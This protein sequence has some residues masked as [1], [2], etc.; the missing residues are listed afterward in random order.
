MC[1]NFQIYYFLRSE[2]QKSK[3]RLFRK[4]WKP[5]CTRKTPRT[6]KNSVF[7]QNENFSWIVWSNDT[8]HSLERKTLFWK[9]T[10]HDWIQ[11]SWHYFFD[12][13]SDCS[14]QLS[15]H[16]SMFSKTSEILIFKTCSCNLRLQE[17]FR[18]QGFRHVLTR[19]CLL[20]SLILSRKLTG[21]LWT[22]KNHFWK[23]S[24]HV[25]YPSV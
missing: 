13:D 23:L 24:L 14:E 12:S 5:C 21:S 16:F 20:L 17:N 1:A 2:L 11:L 7:F 8:Y 19:F 6:H 25:W 4:H 18:N 9:T 10:F 15:T 3:N 22:R